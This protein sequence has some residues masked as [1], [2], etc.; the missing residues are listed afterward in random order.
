MVTLPLYVPAVN[1]AGFTD[2]LTV[3][4]VA[5]LAGVALSHVAE[6]VVVT[7][8]INDVLLLPTVRDCAAGALPP[9]CAVNESEA[10]VTVKF[11][12]EA[13]VTVKVTDTDWGEL[14]APVLATETVPM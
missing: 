12:C 1:P 5:P 9:T 4:G 2:T 7:A 10:G 6:P 3:P 8:N 11:G 13:A 14:A